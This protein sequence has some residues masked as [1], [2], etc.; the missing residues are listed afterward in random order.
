MIE[1]R[2]DRQR[3]PIAQSQLFEPLKE[4]AVDQSAAAAHVEKKL[5]TGDGSG[6]A[7]KL[8]SCHC[9]SH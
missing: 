6:C 5:R 9:G 1:C 2:I 7:E 4:A 3:V 8:K